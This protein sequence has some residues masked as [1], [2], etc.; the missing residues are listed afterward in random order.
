SA[1][2]VLVVVSQLAV[3]RLEWTSK[4]AIDL[5]SGPTPEAARGPAAMLLAFGALAFATRMGCRWSVVHAARNLGYEV[6]AMILA[7]LH[8]LGAT[9][10]RTMTPGG[11]VTRATDDLMQVRLL[12]GFGIVHVLGMLL[13]LASALQVM[14][15]LSVLSRLLA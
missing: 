11:I 2:T 10:A 13:G 12:A 6:R 4:T 3:N 14:L 8:E 15:G 1:G 5:V 9:F 7:R